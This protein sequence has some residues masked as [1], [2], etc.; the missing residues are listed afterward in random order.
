M[1]SPLDPSLVVPTGN[2]VSMFF[3]FAAAFVLPR[4]A[5]TRALSI[6]LAVAAALLASF[7]PVAPLAEWPRA[8]FLL[9]FVPPLGAAGVVLWLRRG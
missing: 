5:S 4:R 6:L 9:G 2:V 8:A 3:V 7:V 1:A